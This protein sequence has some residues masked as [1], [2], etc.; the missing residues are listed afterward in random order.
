VTF[1]QRIVAAHP[2]PGKQPWAKIVLVG[3]GAMN[4]ARMQ[5]WYPVGLQF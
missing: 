5:F 2:T 4:A 3:P 1:G